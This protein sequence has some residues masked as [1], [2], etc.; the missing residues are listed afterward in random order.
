MKN[1]RRKFLVNKSIQLKLLAFAGLLIILCPAVLYYIVYYNVINEMLV[2]EA[3]IQVLFPALR[4]VN[5]VL[6]VLTPV[7]L[8]MILRPFLA[9]T[10]KIAGPLYNVEKTLDEIAKGN[11]D[12]RVKLRSGDE[13]KSFA[14][15]MNLALDTIQGQR[16]MY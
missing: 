9:Y 2:P 5:A 4:K 8:F 16:K 10:N 7:A 3:I 6:L 12:Q 15:K 13:L 1:R 11:L 14:D